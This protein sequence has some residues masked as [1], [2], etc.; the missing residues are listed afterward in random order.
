MAG[1]NKIR[2]LWIIDFVLFF[3]VALGLCFMLMFFHVGKVGESDLDLSADIPGTQELEQMQQQA[4]YLILVNKNHGLA[5]DYEPGDLTDVNARADDRASQ[6]QKIR[7]AAA[8]AFDELAA[9]A[10][11]EGYT[12]K[13]TTGYR[14]YSYQKELH[15]SYVNRNGDSWTEQYSAEP[16]YSEHQTGLSADVSGESVGYKLGASFANAPEGKWLAEN[17]HRF[18]FIIRYPD[19]KEDIT[20]YAYEPWHI[21]YVGVDVATEIYNQKLTLEEYLGDV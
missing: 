1:R 19:G 20:G 7:R 14:S 21:R 13:L 2:E 15:D 12:I 4:E 9:N 5:S 10:K 17:A 16:G 3:V 8:E 6:Y 18:G 11:S